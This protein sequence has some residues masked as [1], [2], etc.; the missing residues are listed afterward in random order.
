VSRAEEFAIRTKVTVI[1]TLED[2]AHLACHPHTVIAEVVQQPTGPAYFVEHTDTP[3]PHRFGPF[4][5]NR[6]KAGW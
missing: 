4:T 6:L 5:R 3:Q 2:P 1:T